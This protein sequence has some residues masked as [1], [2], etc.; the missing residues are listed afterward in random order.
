VGWE[1]IPFRDGLE[2]EHVD[3]VR[4]C[5]DQLELRGGVSLRRQGFDQPLDS[6]RGSGGQE[7]RAP[8]QETQELAAR[9][10]GIPGFGSVWHSIRRG[11]FVVE[12]AR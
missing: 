6:G 7:E 1:Q 4:S 8:G 11:A 12:R 9:E 3:G 10:E 2:V 5:C